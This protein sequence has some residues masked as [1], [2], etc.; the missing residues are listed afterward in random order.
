MLLDFDLICDMRCGRWIG[1][2]VGFGVG[3][4]LSCEGLRDVFRQLF[5]L[6]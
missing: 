4:V 2:V 3:I 6:L 1:N 5:L